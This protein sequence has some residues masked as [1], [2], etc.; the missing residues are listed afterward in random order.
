MPLGFWKL[1]DED[2]G[3]VERGMNSR[4]LHVLCPDCGTIWASVRTRG[5]SWTCSHTRCQQCGSGS[6]VGADWC[7]RPYSPL[8]LPHALLLRELEL[9]TSRPDAYNS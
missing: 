1:G 9:A 3:A 5:S 7:S 8:N 4:S 2:M 6:L